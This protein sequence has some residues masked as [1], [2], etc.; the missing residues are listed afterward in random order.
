[1]F[2]NSIALHNT[3]LAKIDMLDA[4]P[5]FA[6]DTKAIEQAIFSLLELGVYHVEMIKAAQ[7]SSLHV[8]LVRR[9]GFQRGRVLFGERY[10]LFLCE[11]CFLYLFATTFRIGNGF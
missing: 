8:H 1:M 4:V 11:W 6:P 9:Y 2:M 5:I 7:I 3:A 10:Q